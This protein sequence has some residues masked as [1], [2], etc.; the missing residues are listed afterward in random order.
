MKTVLSA[1]SAAR[2]TRALQKTIAVAT[3]TVEQ[4]SATL[5][6]S[7]TPPAITAMRKVACAIQVVT[8][9]YQTVKQCSTISQLGT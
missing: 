2:A 5:R 4:N 1:S 3:L 6:C 7:P 9:S 8:T